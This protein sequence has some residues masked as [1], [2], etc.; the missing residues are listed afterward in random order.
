M[1][2]MTK[3]CESSGGIRYPGRALDS[4]ARKSKYL[5]SRLANEKGRIVE[6]V[7]TSI[8]PAYSFCKFSIEES[9]S[10]A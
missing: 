6:A 7:A 1:T 9:V 10:G 4:L 3:K 2:G 5:D 8:M